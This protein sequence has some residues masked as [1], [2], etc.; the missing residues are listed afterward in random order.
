MTRHLPLTEE[1]KASQ[2]TSSR[3]RTREQ[4]EKIGFSDE[5]LYSLQQPK[6]TQNNRVYT[7]VKKKVC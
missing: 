1:I 3:F 5:K 2:T 4:L 7:M 6:N